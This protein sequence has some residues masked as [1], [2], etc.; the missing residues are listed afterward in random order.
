MV[1]TDDINRS[2][3]ALGFTDGSI[4]CCDRAWL[5]K[6]TG[7]GEVN[8]W[9]NRSGKRLADVGLFFDFSDGQSNTL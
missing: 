5:R 3:S 6:A 9:V 1:V 2:L 4:C 8:G 7:D